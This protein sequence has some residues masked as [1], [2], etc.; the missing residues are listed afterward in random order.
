MENFIYLA[1][2]SIGAFLMMSAC[3]CIQ[4][5]GY[6]K[7]TKIFYIPNKFYLFNG[8]FGGFLIIASTMLMKSLDKVFLYALLFTLLVVSLK[9]IR[10]YIQESKARKK[11]EK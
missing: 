8:I 7:D 11:K 4:I 3:C 6:D 1:G 10:L 2:N 5:E 9:T